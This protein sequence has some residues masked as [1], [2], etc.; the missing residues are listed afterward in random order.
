[1]VWITVGFFETT[2]ARVSVGGVV[3]ENSFQCI[4]DAVTLVAKTAMALASGMPLDIV[5]PPGPLLTRL[6]A[7]MNNREVLPFLE[8]RPVVGSGAVLRLSKVQVVRVAHIWDGTTK[9]TRQ[10]TLIQDL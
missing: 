3:Y 2:A 6:E 8:V 10:V 9:Q 7:A 1:M 5:I 4:P